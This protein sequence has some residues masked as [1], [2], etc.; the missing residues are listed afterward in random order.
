MPGDVR[1]KATRAGGATGNQKRVG[2]EMWV[3]MGRIMCAVLR[4]A[5]ERQIEATIDAPG[6]GPPSA[7]TGATWMSGRG[8]RR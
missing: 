5:H 2:R 3:R 6:D 4:E 1:R 7:S 8:E